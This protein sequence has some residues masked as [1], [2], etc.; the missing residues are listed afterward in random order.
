VALDEAP[1]PRRGPSAFEGVAILQGEPDARVLLVSSTTARAAATLLLPHYVAICPAG[2]LGKSDW[3]LLAGRMV[4]I[5]VGGGARCAAIAAEYASRLLPIAGQVRIIDMGAEADGRDLPDM[6]AD[7]WDSARTLA[8]MGPL[9]RAI[10][11]P[12]KPKAAA[13]KANGAAALPNPA[14][15]NGAAQETP[16]TPSALAIWQGLQLDCDAKQVPHPTL[17]NVATIMRAH[18]ELSGK[19]WFDDFRHRIMYGAEYWTDAHELQLTCWIQQQLRLPKVSLQMVGHAARHAAFTQRR[20][21]VTTWLDSLVWD[22]EPRLEDWLADFLGA[23]R[24]AYTQA[25][26]RNWLIQMVARAY[27]PGCQADHMPVLEGASGRGKSSAIAIIGGEWYQAISQEFGGKPFLEAI[28]GQWLVEIP[29]MAGFGRRE[30]GQII[31]AITTRNDH[32]RDSYGRNAEDHAR[33][34]I[35][36]ATSE[37]DDYLHDPRG[38]RR[39]WP[40]RCTELNL[41][42]LTETRTQL[43]AEAVHAFKAGATW[44]AMPERETAQEQ[45][46]RQEGHIWLR[47]IANY[48]ASLRSVTVAD[49]ASFCLIIET[50][51][52]AERSIEMGIAKCLKLLGWRSKVE[53]TNGAPQRVYRPVTSTAAD[54]RA[55]AESPHD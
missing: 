17:A 34:T 52:Q 38:V 24:N 48:C 35:F 44:H 9:V 32:Y 16:A 25:L 33:V 42:A 27:K 15:A 40:I 47:P 13:K 53:W 12:E 26:G 4:D 46:E 28:Q 45:A 37:T 8:W 29:D 6:V 19:L 36:A 1:P 23:P 2:P 43:F 54:T 49:I 22:A 14:K 5:L 30:H 10:A 39:Y 50:K 11:Q 31:S 21:S 55:P 3:Q 41:D 7:A 51:G 18:S 20:N